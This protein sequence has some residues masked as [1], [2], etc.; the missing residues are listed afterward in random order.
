MRTY[1]VA[2]LAGGLAEV[3]AHHGCELELCM[4]HCVPG[5]VVL[6]AFGG[7]SLSRTWLSRFVQMSRTW[8]VE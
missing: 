1:M 8:Q 6:Y 4:L 7:E 3:C 5:A 2:S